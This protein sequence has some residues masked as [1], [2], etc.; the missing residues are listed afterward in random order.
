[1]VV[2]YLRGLLKPEL[3]YGRRSEAAEEAIFEA[4]AADVQVQNH[5]AVIAA[6]SSALPI[7]TDEGKDKTLRSLRA[8]IARCHELRMMDIYRLDM[9]DLA[10]PV[11]NEISLYQLYHL[12]AKQGILDA[13]QEYNREQE[14][15]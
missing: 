2:A 5:L 13:L 1:M 11:K 14:T 8:R 6:E 4:L 12:A 10:T 7:F 15:D 3:M 9:R